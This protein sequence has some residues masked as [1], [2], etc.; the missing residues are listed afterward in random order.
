MGVK[1]IIILSGMIAGVLIGSEGIFV[2]IEGIKVAGVGLRRGERAARHLIN[3]DKDK[4][5]SANKKGQT[6]PSGGKQAEANRGKQAEANKRRQTEA[7]KRR[8]A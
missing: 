3:I 8:R 5:S 2:F 6:Q 1:D 7:N 4:N